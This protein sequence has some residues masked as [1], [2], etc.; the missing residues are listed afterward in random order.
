M[1]VKNPE[2]FLAIVKEH[3]ISKA[4]ERL[5]LSQPY[6]SQYLAK[7][8]GSLGVVLL[9]RSRSPLKLT[10]AGE[11]FHAYLERQ[12]FLDRQLV[13]DLRDLQDKKR[14]VLHIGVSPWRG[15]TLLPDVLPL[16]EGQYPDVQVVLH[17]APVPELGDLAA[18]NVIDFCVMQ[19]PGDLHELTYETV[20]REHIFL[21]CHRDHPLLQG[22]SSTYDD[23]RPFPDLRLLE[24]ERVIMLPAE[25]RLSKLLY[26]T[27][28]VHSVEP[29]N[30]LVTTNTTTAINLAAEKLG[31]AFLQESGV[32]RTPYLDRL[33]CFTVGDPPLTCPLVVVYK[34]NGFLSPAARTFINLIK[35]F[36]SRYDR[37]PE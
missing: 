3:S 22:I 32:S 9:D 28:S 23:P 33:A 29:Q 31:F 15:S 25:W 36:Y 34:K 6:L 35:E 2:Y 1:F 10:P 8:E 7:L 12:S 24:H 5:Y 26:N 11:L 37:A 30:I 4:A 17:E 18:A 19:I 16:F 20:M 27:F 14:P 21:V 13:S